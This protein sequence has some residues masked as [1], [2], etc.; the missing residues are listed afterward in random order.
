MTQSL[1][2]QW[3]RK[4]WTLDILEMSWV[5]DTAVQVDFI[6][7]A[8]ELHP[9]ERILDLACGFGRHSLE[10]ARRGY[11]VHGVDITPAYIA[12]AR[13]Q[14]AEQDLSVDF[15]CADLREVHFSAEFDAVLN[16]A[17][18]AI[19]YLEDDA[20][21]LKIFDLVRAAL[22]PG[23]RHLMEVCSG[24]YARRHFPRRTWEA[25]SRA[26][27]LADFAWDA[28]NQRMLYTGYTFPYGEPLRA[29][30]DSLPTSTRL[31]TLEEVKAILAERG[32]QVQAAFAGYSLT[33]ASPDSFEMV[34]CSRK[35]HP[36]PDK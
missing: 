34:V 4:I 18:G 24:D 33:P 9:G 19:G 16:L 5:E 17:D 15:T 22:K 28:E 1:D 23:G 30:Q 31:Y 12:Y 35:N 13:D 3:Y 7:N 20:E 32:M 8:L 11:T 27:S 26:L 2:P 14:A 36:H 29:P 6:I 25:G 21:N 10:L